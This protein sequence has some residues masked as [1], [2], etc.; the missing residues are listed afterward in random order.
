MVIYAHHE[1]A[2]EVKELLDILMNYAQKNAD[3][4]VIDRVNDIFVD[5]LS[6]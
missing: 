2:Q 3:D 1:D 5:T 6:E 4:E